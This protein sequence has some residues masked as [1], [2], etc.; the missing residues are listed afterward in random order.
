MDEL[1]ADYICTSHGL[2]LSEGVFLETAKSPLKRVE[3]TC[4]P[5]PVSAFGYY[6]WS[7]DAVPGL[8]ARLRAL[9]MNVFE[10]GFT[11]RFVP[12]ETKLSAA[13][14]FRKRFAEAV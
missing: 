11:A 4:F 1:D 12:P 8:I 9:K 6:G 7:S 5:K 3:Q 14:D 13:F 10:E 2:I